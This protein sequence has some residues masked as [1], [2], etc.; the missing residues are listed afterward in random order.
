MDIE[1]I[2]QIVNETLKI[3]N[4]NTKAL[5][6]DIINGMAEDGII[7]IHKPRDIKAFL[8]KIKERCVDAGIDCKNWIVDKEKTLTKKLK[9]RKFNR[10]VRKLEKATEKVERLEKPE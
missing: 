5:V 7:K 1:E 9:E 6:K 3:Q 2:K 4:N 8:R 10:N